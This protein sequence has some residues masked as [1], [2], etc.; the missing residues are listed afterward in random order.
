MFVFIGISPKEKGAYTILDTFLA[1]SY[2]TH[3]WNQ[4]TFSRNVN[5]VLSKRDPWQIKCFIENPSTNILDCNKIKDFLS[6]LDIQCQ[7]I[8]PQGWRKQFSLN[9]KDDEAVIN[10]AKE[11]HAELGR[12][13]P[14]PEIINKSE[15][16]ESLMIACYAH[17]RDVANYWRRKRSQKEGVCSK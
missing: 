2:E 10:A 15:A 1:T 11:F 16:A 8:S 4:N 7:I 9:N 14:A 13:H 5:H 3:E 6:S 12:W 17:L